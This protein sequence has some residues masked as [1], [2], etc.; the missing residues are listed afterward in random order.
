VTWEWVKRI[1]E[2]AELPAEPNVYE[3][4]VIDF[5]PGFPVL[6]PRKVNLGHL[7]QPYHSIELLFSNPGHAAI[8]VDEL[9]CSHPTMANWMSPSKR[10]QLLDPGCLLNLTA[11]VRAA[12]LCPDTYR[13]TLSVLCAA[14]GALF[15]VHTTIEFAV[16][17]N[18]SFLLEAFPRRILVPRRPPSDL[19]VELCN[20]SDSAGDVGIIHR[21]FRTKT[22]DKTI[23][24]KAREA[25]I[26]A[27]PASEVELRP[28]S[29]PEIR[30]VNFGTGDYVAVPVVPMAQP[31]KGGTN[32]G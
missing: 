31:P 27:F 7:S 11:L 1:K 28:M 5:P 9:Q 26:H 16:P 17:P 24:M 13:A 8:K 25:L 22:L 30:L 19:Q 29:R 3:V 4:K 21:N 15:P 12:G 14:Q 10:D 32:D 18:G 6:M 2:I 23:S 20:Y